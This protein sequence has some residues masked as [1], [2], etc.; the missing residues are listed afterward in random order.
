MKNFCQIYGC[1]NI[2]K[3][4]TCFR[5]PINPTCIDLIIT[6]RPKSIQDS[7]AIETGLS[8][9]HKMSFTVMKVFYNKQNP[10]II[11]YRKHKGFSNETFMHELESVLAGFPQISFGTFKST[12]GN[13]LQKHDAKTD[14]DRIA[15]NKQRNYCV[16][17]IR[18]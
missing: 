6:N 4:K 18:K 5:N 9:F 7:E 12:V 17:L 11:Q 16:S 1:K 14:G 2:V 15:Y 8:D 3:D 13:I 10:K